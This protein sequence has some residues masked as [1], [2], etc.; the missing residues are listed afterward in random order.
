LLIAVSVPQ[1]ALA[2]GGSGNITP[3]G[4]SVGG[5]GG[6]DGDAASAAG[7]DGGP[8]ISSQGGTGG[9]GGVNLDTGFG[10]PGGGYGAPN[11]GTKAGVVGVTG[12]YGL[13][14]VT[15]T[16]ITTAVGGETGGLGPAAVGVAGQPGSVGAGGQGGGGVGIITSANIIVGTGGVVTGG[17][18]G[19]GSNTGTAAGGGGG[20]GVGI[21]S[22]ADVT[23]LN[24]GQVVGG[25]GGRSANSGG[26]GGAAGVLLAGGGTLVNSG[27]ISGGTGGQANLNA[28]GGGGAGVLLTAGGSVTNLA[29]GTISGGKGGASG[30][31]VGP[32]GEGIKGANVHVIN[33]GSIGGNVAGGSGGVR[34]NAITFTGG[35]NSLELWSTS[36]ITG[37]VVAFS[38]ADKFILG[39]ATDGTFDVSQLGSA[40]QYQGFGVFEKTGASTWVLSGASTGQTPWILT[41]GTLSIN[42]DQQLGSLLGGVTLN[43]GTL[44]FTS[45]ISS[46]RNFSIGTA[47][48]TFDLQ[49]GPVTLS[50]SISGEGGLVMTGGNPL[51]LLGDNTYT[52]GT[53]VSAGILT[54][55]GGGTTGSIRGDIVNNGQVTFRRSDDL[56]YA[57]SISGGGRVVQAGAGTLTLTGNS[58]YTG[59]TVVQGGLQLGDG[60]TSGSVTGNI[61]NFGGLVFNRA[62]AWTYG[63]AII[64]TGNIEQRGGGRVTLSGDSSAFSGNTVISNGILAVN[65]MLGGTLSVD[66]GILQGR[67]SVGDVTNNA[68]GIIAPGNSIGTLS[69]GNYLS[70]GG[71]L[72]IEAELGG[73][74][75]PADLL[76]V[77]GDSI[78]GSGATRVR[79]L[80]LGGVGGPTT[81]GIRIVQVDGVS[82]A[83]VFTLDGT[84]I[85]GAYLYSLSQG[86]VGDAEDGD[87]YLR[88]SGDFAPTV[89][90]F[91]NYPVALLSMLTELP[92][93]RQRIG[94]LD[95][96]GTGAWGRLETSGGHGVG[97]DSTVGTSFD[98][99]RVVGQGGID[100][101]LLHGDFGTLRGGINAQVGQHS[102]EVFSGIGD[103]ANLTRSVG[104]GGTLTWQNQGGTYVDLQGQVAGFLSDLS[105]GGSSLVEDN[106]G[107]GFAV[108]LETG[109]RFEIDDSLAI[110]P[111]AQLSY[112]AATFDRFTD[113]HGSVVEADGAQSLK[114]R[115][116]V[117][118]DHR[119]E[120]LDDAGRTNSATIYGVGNVTYE[121]LGETRVLVGET[122]IAYTPQRFGAELGFGGSLSLNDGAIELHGEL[123]GATSFAG[124][125][126]V[127]A[128]GGI[129][130]RF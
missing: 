119:G 7:D 99:R 128:T 63:G 69:V 16:T 124:S 49:G 20:G 79:V 56:V 125:H 65:G 112:A 29:G 96:E 61:S 58:T 24:F 31:A 110:T 123:L 90:V 116:G 18:G 13:S 117:V 21:F 81:D 37:N 89:P 17:T 92:T 91:E 30:R 120:W 77:H 53:T 19:G 43:G 35:T 6:I 114:T 94:N 103:G 98:D 51:T 47:G 86:S 84:T 41:G 46:S 26:G 72:A 85:G 11:N 83:G 14:L 25:T 118:I 3:P 121:A 105:A 100:G 59:P 82:D 64:G 93:M 1:A 78:L 36:A 27:A 52:G 76:W 102:A 9:G 107:Y 34:A 48:G 55:G 113:A 23:V 40:G 38:A 104:V 74:G 80:N 127:K 115:L 2:D 62:D 44:A 129:K 108:S 106:K 70:N 109:H 73:D 67:G 68:G 101:V 12:A 54:I 5:P 45:I 66:H 122:P 4:G 130:G 75:S 8:G 33:A 10:A 57:G 50:G 95:A 15:A 32:G 71:V 60:G 126:S 87:W 88:S 111:Q 39:G 28:G 97:G 22:A 42:D